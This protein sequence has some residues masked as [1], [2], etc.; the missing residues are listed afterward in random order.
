MVYHRPLQTLG[1]FQMQGCPEGQCINTKKWKPPATGST[2]ALEEPE[3]R[4][5]EL[6]GLVLFKFN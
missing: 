3:E 6:A 4:E 1:I 2:A 5:R